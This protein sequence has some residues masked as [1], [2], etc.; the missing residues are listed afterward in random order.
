LPGRATARGE[1]IAGLTVAISCVPDG[2]AAG[3][4]AG[5]NPINGLYASMV[6]PISGGALAS[7]RVLF[8]TTT[9]AASLAAGQAL[10]TT[11]ADGRA[12]AILLLTLLVGVFQVVAGALRLGSLTRFV[13]HSVMTGFLTGVA[14][15]IVLGQLGHF[16]GYAA[17]GA[18]RVAQTIDLLGNA[19]GI[20]VRTTA[21]GLLTLIL[22]A[23]L[24]RTRLGAF[25]TLLALALPSVAVGLLGW[26]SVATVANVGAIPAGL[27]LPALPSLAPLSL[28]LLTGALAVAAIILVQGAGVGQANPNPEGRASASRDFLAQGVANVATG[29]FRAMPVGGSVGQTALSV[30]AGAR[31]RWAAIFAGIWMAAIL[32]LFAGLVQ[33]VA[34]PCLAALLILVG[35]RSIKVEEVASIWST[36]WPS[37][38]TIGTT[39]V[40]TLFLPIQVAVAIGAV[41]SG[42]LH[43]FAA[44]TDV[45]VVQIIRRPD[46]RLEEQPPPQVLPSNSVT[47]LDVH[48]SVF[49]AGA[50]TL[51]RS[52][53]SPIG[54][55]RPALI[56]RLRDHTQVGATFIEVMARYSAQLQAADGR[57][58]LTG[59]SAHVRDQLIRTGKLGVRDGRTHLY[60]ATPI[61]GES[62][63]LAFRDAEA[64]QVLPAE[65]STSDASD[66]R[67]DG[68]SPGGG[69]LS[70]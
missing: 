68:I 14:V 31:T 29:L 62:T 30:R 8:V 70:C 32:L 69:G 65:T 41:L 60:A 15:N 48:G 54:T 42:L 43:L 52:L 19:R 64:W 3:L 25:G 10:T 61:L 49:Y 17:S 27:P 22:A 47:V 2:M 1:A 45:S 13:S 38:L 11:S 4:L 16:T 20:D 56:L 21:I 55:R 39:L 12:E 59:L 57:L 9:S 66:Q 18:N 40:A 50:R 46:G 34:M 33:R 44:S 6:G 24:P 7:T 53:P 37:R 23:L 67:S 5:V 63:E 35:Y 28:N 58:Y 36:G 26:E 51:E